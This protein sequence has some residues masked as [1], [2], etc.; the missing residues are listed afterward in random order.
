MTMLVMV[1]MVVIMIVVLYLGRSLYLA[2]T[3]LHEHFLFLLVDDENP[4]LLKLLFRELETLS[5][6]ITKE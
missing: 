4:Q 3:F 1:M 2:R 6:V 5:S